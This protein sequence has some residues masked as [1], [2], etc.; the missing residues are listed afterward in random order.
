[1]K[2]SKKR[3]LMH[4]NGYKGKAI[5]CNFDNEMTSLTIVEMIDEEPKDVM[6][7]REEYIMARTHQRNEAQLFTIKF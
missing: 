4:M 3:A 5:Q 7:T 6:T 2:Y 1:M